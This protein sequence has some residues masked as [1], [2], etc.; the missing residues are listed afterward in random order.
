MRLLLVEDDLQLGMQLQQNLQTAG[1]VVDLVGSGT[2]AGWM[3][4]EVRYDIAVLDLGLPDQ[5]GTT[6]L[7]QWREHHNH[8]PVLIL[9]ARSDWEEKVR[10]FKAGADDYVCKPFRQE[11]LLARLEAL[12]RRSQPGRCPEKQL[13]AL[14]IALDVDNEEAVIVHSGEAV[15][16]TSTEFRLMQYFVRNPG[17]LIRRKQL[18]DQLYRFDTER[19]SNVVESYV[20][21]LRRKF[22]KQFLE[23]RRFQGYIYRGVQ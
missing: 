10:C 20:R 23:T 12:L 22:G 11:E 16:L 8:T 21:R 7:T 6:L 5:C 9:T 3:M 4:N 1:Y 19:E 17:R 13:Q 2:D 15:S 18:L 14:G